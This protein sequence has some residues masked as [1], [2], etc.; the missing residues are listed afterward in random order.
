MN[1]WF[2]RYAWNNHTSGASRV[3]VIEDLESGRMVGY[4]AICASQIER[5]YRPK[6]SQRNQPDPVPVTLLG[7]VAVDKD[8]QGRG[9]AAGLVAFAF[10]ASLK[11]PKA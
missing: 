5:V 4:I 2:R 11:L 3:S 7:Q 9:Y 6:A 1:A 8:W 10:R